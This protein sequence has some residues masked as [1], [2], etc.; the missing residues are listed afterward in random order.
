MS[1]MCGVRRRVCG[2]LRANLRVGGSAVPP[3]PA[4]RTRY[5]RRKLFQHWQRRSQR[6]NRL[7][8]RGGGIWTTAD[9]SSQTRFARHCRR[10]TIEAS[11]KRS[12]GIRRTLWNTRALLAPA[13]RRTSDNTSYLPTQS[14]N[15][16]HQPVDD[17]EATPY[18]RAQPGSFLDAPLAVWQTRSMDGGLVDAAGPLVEGTDSHGHRNHH[19]ACR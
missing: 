16:T 9:T 4:P 10:S 3:L 8:R 12:P 14:G 17:P 15:I 1:V 5:L 13:R 7:L 2:A 18:L 19:A 6:V 11:P